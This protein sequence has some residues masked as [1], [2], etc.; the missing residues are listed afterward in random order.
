MKRIHLSYSLLILT[1]I[2]FYFSGCIDNKSGTNEKKYCGIVMKPDEI[3]DVKRNE[4]NYNYSDNDW[5]IHSEIAYFAQ[6]IAGDSIIVEV[7]F[8][9]SNENELGIYLSGP[10]DPK[11][12]EALNCAIING[13]Y[14]NNVAPMKYILY[15][16]END[17]SLISAIKSPEGSKAD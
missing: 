17:E 2:T 8:I 6:K 3:S 16:N 7:F 11:I 5:D 10:K 12:I 15:Y 13:K 4:K 14:E 9:L 1:S